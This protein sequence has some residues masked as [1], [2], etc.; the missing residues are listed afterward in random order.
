MW[1]SAAGGLYLLWCTLSKP[2]VG[3][4]EIGMCGFWGKA[5][6]GSSALQA[7]LVRELR[8]TIASFLGACA[9]GIYFDLVRHGEVLRHFAARRCRGEGRRARLPARGVAARRQGPPGPEGAPVYLARCILAGCGKSVAW[10]R[11]VLYQLLDEAHR[12]H[13]PHELST[14]SWVD[15][16]AA[17]I[18][19]SEESCAKVVVDTGQFLSQAAQHFRLVISPKSMIMFNRPGVSAKVSKALQGM[20][21]D[22]K[23][24]TLTKDLGLGTSAIGRGRNA[25]HQQER[26]AMILLGKGISVDLRLICFSSSDRAP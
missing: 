1:E 7:A 18:Q 25:L 12:R 9:G 21:I 22:L 19:G 6:A 4:C 14:E 26:R 20:G 2:L 11:A 17:I 16:F 8:H 24:G 13:R 10:R 3:E 5:V 23:A 15:A